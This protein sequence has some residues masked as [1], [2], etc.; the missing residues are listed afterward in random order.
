[1][2]VQL[3][4]HILVAIGMMKGVADRNMPPLHLRA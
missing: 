1:M 3:Y 4:V 2:H